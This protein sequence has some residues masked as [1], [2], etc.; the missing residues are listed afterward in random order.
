MRS[1]S[2]RKHHDIV[3]WTSVRRS[4]TQRLERPSLDLERVENR[5]QIRRSAQRKPW[6]ARQEGHSLCGGTLCRRHCRG[7][8]HRLEL[9]QT[10]GAPRRRGQ[11]GD[12]RH[13]AIELERAQRGSVHRVKGG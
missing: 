12:D 10:G 1:A 8:G 7:I 3:S 13:D 11:T 9:G 6:I 4:E 5:F 2:G